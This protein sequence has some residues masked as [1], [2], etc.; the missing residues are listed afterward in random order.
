MRIANGA[1][2]RLVPT[3]SSRERHRFFDRRYDFLQL[4]F[5]EAER[6]FAEDVLAGS[7]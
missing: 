2:R 6:F 7:Q 1:N 4:F 5:V 3:M